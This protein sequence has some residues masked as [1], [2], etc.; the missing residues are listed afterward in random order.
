MNHDFPVA[1]FSTVERR[2][3]KRGAFCFS[4]FTMAV[5]VVKGKGAGGTKYQKVSL[6][7]SFFSAST[8]AF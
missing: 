8:L 2:L 6:T 4:I 3:K 5:F 7:T 1:C